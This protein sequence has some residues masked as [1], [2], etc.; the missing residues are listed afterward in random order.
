V[1]LPHVVVARL[2]VEALDAEPAQEDVAGCLHQPLADDHAP[3]VMTVHAH[4]H[5]PLEHR[6]LRFLRLQEQ[7]VA[8]VASDEEVDPRPG[9][10]A[11][12][13]DDLAR[14]VDV[15][16]LLDRMV[17]IGERS[18]VFLHE[19]PHQLLRL[20]AGGVRVRQVVDRHDQRRIG[21]DA[22]LAVDLVG[23]FREHP[24]AVAGPRLRDV[25]L[26]LLRLLLAE[27]V[28]GDLFADP[29]HDLLDVHVVVPGI[30]SAHLSRA[31][32]H[33]AVLAHARLDDRPSV[34]G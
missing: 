16:E 20:V 10:D 23:A 13:A 33:E 7:G 5:E 6:G 2:A 1:E 11:P 24:H 19:R 32:H 28:S 29:A 26:R 31:P 12:D 21:D 18:P 30:E 9:A 14:G 3:T 22:Q 34:V 8:V 15:V 4:A 25:L 17:M 27:P